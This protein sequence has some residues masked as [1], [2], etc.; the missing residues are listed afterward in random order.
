[1]HRAIAVV[2]AALLA[3]AAAHAQT[4]G[5]VPPSSAWVM[6]STEQLRADFDTIWAV[7]DVHGW[8]E[9]FDQ[10]LVA[11]HLVTRDA[12]GGVAWDRAQRRQLFLAVGD[13][14]NGG[15]ESVGVVL[16]LDELTKQAAAAG[17]RVVAL[18]GNHEAEFLANPATADRHLLANA[19]RRREDLGL[20]KRPT[21]EQLSESEFGRFLRGLP[22][23]AFVGSWLFAHAGYID[24]KVDRADVLAYFEGLASTWSHEGAERYR[25]VLDPTSIVNCHDWWRHRGPRSRMRARLAEIGLDGLLFGHDPDALGLHEKIGMDPDGW[26]IKLD[27]GMKGT[28]SRGML[29][30]CDVARIVQGT[31]LAMTT[32]GRPN[33]QALMPDGKLMD[34]P[35]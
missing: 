33:C 1:M 7:S 32:D 11:A 21:P 34:L 3:S 16:R 29:L 24:A 12:E 23:A 14:I 28:S 18:L 22:V 10:L 2:L 19:H 20:P 5:P 31:R 35:H 8:L 17:S 27:S 9:D 15:R 25:V 26:M 4:P 30:R 6:I 13:Y